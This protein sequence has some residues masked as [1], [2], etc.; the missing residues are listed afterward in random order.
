MIFH[1]H[2]TTLPCKW[3]SG[4]H[5][6]IPL[7]WSFYRFRKRYV[8]IFPIWSYVDLWPTVSAILIFSIEIKH[9]RLKRP[10]TYHMYSL[11]ST[12]QHHSKN[13]FV[14]HSNVKPCPA[15][16][17]SRLSGYNITYFL[18]HSSRIAHTPLGFD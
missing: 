3:S 10:S 13:T 15:G 6:H 5:S 1:L 9:Q 4:D 8:Y 12:V 11:V 14:I 2:N 17:L 7:V 18:K 16:H